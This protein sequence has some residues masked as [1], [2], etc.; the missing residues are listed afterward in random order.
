MEPRGGNPSAE[1]WRV[2]TVFKFILKYNFLYFVFLSFSYRVQS[3]VELIAA[4][5][6]LQL[7]LREPNRGERN[8]PERRT[9]RA[10]AEAE[11]RASA[12]Q[13]LC[14]VLAEVPDKILNSVFFNLLSYI[15]LIYSTKYLNNTF[16]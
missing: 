2:K 3:R 9:R 10:G 1:L 12:T 14:S 8:V 11:E 15:Q 13:Q 5:V 6:S 16:Q 7:T 4:N